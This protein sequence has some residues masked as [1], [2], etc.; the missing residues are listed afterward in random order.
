MAKRKS[1]KTDIENVVIYCRVSTSEQAEKDLS[2]P[3][4]IKG[5]HKVAEARGFKVV[6][7]YIE[8]GSS[9]RAVDEDRRPI[10][11]KNARRGVER[12]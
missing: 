10:F 2:I 9:A 4:Q 6:K 11:R 8:P 7:E 12:A 5:L 3:A 1:K